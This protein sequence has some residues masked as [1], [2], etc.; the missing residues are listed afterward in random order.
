MPL[1]PAQRHRARVLAELAVA[2]S[3]F[4]EETQGSDYQLQLAKLAADKR[5]LKQIESIQLK[6]ETK[7]RLLPVHLP[8]VEAALAKGQ[9]AQDVVVTTVMVWAIDAGA[10]ELAARI[11]AYV[12]R[13]R[14]KMPDQYERS[15]AAVLLDEFAG[16]YLLGQWNALAAQSDELGGHML[17][18][19]TTPAY[20]ALLAV[21]ALTAELDAPDQARAKL[22]KAAAYAL[23][24]KVQT[25]ETPNL[26]ALPAE[27]LQAALALLHQAITL[28]AL[29]GAKKDIERIERKLRAATDGR[30]T[31]AEGSGPEA[32][33]NKSAA[34]KPAPSSAPKQTAARKRTAPAKTAGRQRAAQ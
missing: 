22:K 23:L 33:A 11:G 5:T 17:V 20:V 26:E 18:A 31:L 14:L 30:A 15:V 9:G 4:G 32:S 25:A 10:Y 29:C 28:D 13:H 34:K 1:S 21:D 27:T 2:A 19:D 24:G 7:A 12:I 16:A 8:W 3:P 6:R